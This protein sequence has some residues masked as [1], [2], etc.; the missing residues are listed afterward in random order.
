MGAGASASIDVADVACKEIT[1][2]GSQALIMKK[3]QYPKH[4][5]HLYKQR[6][7]QKTADGTVHIAEPGTEPTVMVPWPKAESTSMVPYPEDET[8]ILEVDELEEV[9][10]VEEEDCSTSAPNSPRS[11]LSSVVEILDIPDLLD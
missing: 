3:R 4:V 11:E 9:P 6:C 8:H 10:A 7:I 2:Q 1:R 5:R